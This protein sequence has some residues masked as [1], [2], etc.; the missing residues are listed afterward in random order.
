[1]TEDLSD[2]PEVATSVINYGVAGIAV[3]SAKSADIPRIERDVRQ[4]IIDFEPRIM[5]DT[6]RVSID[7]QSQQHNPSAIVFRIE[8]QMWAQPA[9]EKGQGA[10][11]VR[12]VLRGLRH[13]ARP[14][15]PLLRWRI[16]PHQA[17]EKP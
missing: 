5:K 12:P 8:G 3:T 15:L 13:W 17:G 4:A 6:L 10:L 7:R 16:S 2:Y 11:W 14:G 1:M 9:P